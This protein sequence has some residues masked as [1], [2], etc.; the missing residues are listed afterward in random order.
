M[1]F[2]IKDFFSNFDQIHRKLRIRYLGQFSAKFEDPNSIQLIRIKALISTLFTCNKLFLNCRILTPVIFEDISTKIK[3][4]QI[5]LYH[6][7]HL[8]MTK[9]IWFPQ[10]LRKDVRYQFKDLLRPFWAVL[11]LKNYLT[12]KSFQ[13]LYQFFS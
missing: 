10:K 13:T 9:M 11:S 7:G 12:I 1:K 2:S 4:S 6:K 3:L 8:Q 5:S